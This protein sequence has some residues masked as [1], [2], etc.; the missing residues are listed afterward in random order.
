MSRR[1]AAF[2]TILVPR[3]TV[4]PQTRPVRKTRHFDRDLPGF[5]R[6]ASFGRP[7][8]EAK[9]DPAELLDAPAD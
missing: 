3:P 2:P 8:A 9:F 4:N 6:H 1:D 7:N 5:V